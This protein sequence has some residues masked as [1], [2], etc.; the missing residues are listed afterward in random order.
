MVY[1]TKLNYNTVDIINDDY[2]DDSNKHKNDGGF[3]R[4]SM[5]MPT[6]TMY[7]TFLFF[8]SDIFSNDFCLVLSFL[9]L[10]SST[11]VSARACC[12]NDIHAECPF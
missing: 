10:V 6:F 11:L 9:K 7:S 1:L 3:V 5:H 8:G 12:I 2:N 4:I